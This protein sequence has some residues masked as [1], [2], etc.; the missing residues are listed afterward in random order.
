MKPNVQQDVADKVDAC[1]P[2]GGGE[3]T[4]PGNW[5]TPARFQQRG[6]YAGGVE[7]E[8]PVSPHVH[9]EELLHICLIWP[10][11]N[12]VF[13]SRSLQKR[14][15]DLPAAEEPGSLSGLEPGL[16]HPGS[17]KICFIYHLFTYFFLLFLWSNPRFVKLPLTFI[18]IE[19]LQC[20]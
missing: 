3:E 1:V 8:E 11:L 20:S 17:S 14:R 19:I 15:R 18:H 16:F 13:A 7:L 2:D 4:V 9:L 6:V 10:R 12:Q 5:E